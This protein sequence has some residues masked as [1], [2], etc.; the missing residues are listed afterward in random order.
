MIASANSLA[1][2]QQSFLGDPDNGTAL[3]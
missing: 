3:M 2:S 1:Q